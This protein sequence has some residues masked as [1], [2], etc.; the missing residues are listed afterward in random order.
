M[1]G[2]A[3][4]AALLLSAGA[5][6]AE[7]AA[8]PAPEDAVG[9]VV[10]ALEAVDRDA[11]VAVFGEDARDL[12]LT[13]NDV[14]DRDTWLGFLRGYREM[15]RIAVD[16][17]GEAATLFIGAD[18]W[19]FPAPLV[20]GE[21]GRWRFDPEG[22]RDEVL[23]RRIGENELDVM[24]VL[25]GYVGAQAAYRAVDYDGDGLMEFAPSFL[26]DEGQRNGLYWPEE[27][28]APESPVGDLL[29]RAAA[30]GYR[31]GGADREPDP[32]YGYYFRILTAQ[33][34]AAPGGELDYMVNGHM[35]AGHALLA[36][37]A[38]YGE[39]GIMSFMVG[40]NGIIHEADLG[41]ETL[42]TATAIDRF[43]PDD[44][45]QPVD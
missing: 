22:A 30:A 6:R 4:A 23:A 26:S 13:G 15:H 44:G 37:P 9:A 41:E 1:H 14:R 10:A 33:G 36:F 27:D 7:P 2:A 34:P 16:E 3:L 40:E 31:L 17:S 32:Y 45:W 8:Y 11:L 19:P 21:D 24:D 35:L 12:V 28:G 39:T 5:A 42:A 18:Q 43:L 25:R 38:A 29:A 20:K